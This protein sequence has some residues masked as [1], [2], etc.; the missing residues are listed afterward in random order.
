MC[1]LSLFFHTQKWLFVCEQRLWL[2]CVQAWCSSFLHIIQPKKPLLQ[3]SIAYLIIN[4]NQYLKETSNKDLPPQPPELRH[5]TMLS[6]LTFTSLLIT[7]L[8]ILFS[9]STTALSHKL[10][11]NCRGSAF[12]NSY[13]HVMPIITA[14]GI[15]A[16]RTYTKGEHILCI[17]IVPLSTE[18]ICAFLQGSQ[19]VQ[20]TG[21]KAA[22]L[23]GQLGGHRCGVCGSIPIGYSK[24][25]PKSND[26]KAGILTVNYVTNVKG[27]RGIC[28]ED[29]AEAIQSAEWSREVKP[30]VRSSMV[31]VLDN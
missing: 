21:E 8:T 30:L 7:L 29:G 20:I 18:G 27:C 4:R 10:G 5:T 28:W 13:V 6:S 14:M 22:S 26:P 3:Y 16:T 19:D 1:S 23:L 25:D 24:S 31:Q 15:P 17:A 12:C 9:Q 11:I 2:A